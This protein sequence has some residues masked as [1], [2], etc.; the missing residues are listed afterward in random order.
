LG[1]YATRLHIRDRQPTKNIWIKCLKPMPSRR[2]RPD[3]EFP[4]NP[5]PLSPPISAPS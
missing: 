1:E 5:P 4:N 3:T 2:L